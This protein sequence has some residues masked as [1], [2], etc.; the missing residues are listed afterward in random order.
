MI[1]GYNISTD[2]WEGGG[3]YIEIDSYGNNNNIA[4][5]AKE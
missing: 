1:P 5:Y 2:N 4:G 3:H